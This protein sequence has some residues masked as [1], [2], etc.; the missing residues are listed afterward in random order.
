M[1]H[2]FFYILT[3]KDNQKSFSHEIN[4]L[5]VAGFGMAFFLMF[6]ACALLLYLTEA[7][8][9][10][11]VPKVLGILAIYLV[12]YISYSLF[13]VSRIKKLFLPLDKLAS[14]ILRDQVFIDDGEKDLKDFA[15]SLREQALRME[16]LNKKLKVT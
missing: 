16:E 10:L 5:V 9:R 4:Q 14:G 13:I 7:D 11:Y 12:L 1:Q 2:G 8:H 6:C 3:M 15:K